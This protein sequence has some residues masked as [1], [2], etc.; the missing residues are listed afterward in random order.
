MFSGAL[1]GLG[2]LEKT[3]TCCENLESLSVMLMGLSQS[4][5]PDN[6]VSAGCREAMRDS[7]TLYLTYFPSECDNN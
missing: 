5:E 4:P 7:L 3:G 1:R 6:Q 2:Q